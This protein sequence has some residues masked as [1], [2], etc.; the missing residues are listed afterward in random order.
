MSK[1]RI[2]TVDDEPD[3]IAIIRQTLEP[4]Y[5]VVE[6]HN[7]LDALEKIERFEPDFIILDVMMPLMDGFDTCAAIRKSPQFRQTPIYFLTSSHSPEDIKKGYMLGC[8]LFLQKPFD[9]LRLL[10]NIDFYFE[11][12][13]T[14]PIKKKFSLEALKVVVRKPPQLREKTQPAAP[15]ISAP[16]TPKP[17]PRQTARIMAIDD[18]QATLDF[19]EAALSAK[20][21]GKWIF[22]TVATS[23]PVEALSKIVKY[24]PD[25][26]L[27]DI[28]M[29]KLDGLQLCK[30]IKLNQN[31]QYTE[32]Q[33][34]SAIVGTSD[35]DVALKLTGNP[36][37]KKP[38]DVMQVR[39]AV[40]AICEK[41]SFTLKVKKMAKDEITKQLHIQEQEFQEQIRKA[42][43]KEFQEKKLHSITDYYKEINEDIKHS[44]PQ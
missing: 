7:G 14:P 12:N 37:L 17:I 43:E 13:P 15:A 35:L 16:R 23:N 8:N 26:I 27:L 3:I 31:L 28:R 30:I 32:I 19:V 18:D 2:M 33:F 36:L 40:E 20:M 4:K 38:F 11:Q 22:E 24:E 1:W 34:M 25:I 44:R 5:E 41:P 6:A 42:R 10:K 29:P 9:P 21:E 39:R